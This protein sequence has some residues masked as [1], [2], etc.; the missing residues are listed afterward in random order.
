MRY[1][2]PDG[3]LLSVGF[4]LYLVLKA[5]WL[6]ACVHS[7]RTPG[8]FT[9]ELLD[10]NRWRSCQKESCSRDEIQLW[11]RNTGG[12]ENEYLPNCRFVG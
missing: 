12:R 9:G 11:L 1:I 3:L 7:T 4:I 2:T 5:W 10:I 8:F 6:T